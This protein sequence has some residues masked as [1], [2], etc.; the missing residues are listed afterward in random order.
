M[1]EVVEKGLKKNRHNGLKAGA[2]HPMHNLRHHSD[3]G[4]RSRWN[5]IGDIPHN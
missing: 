4:A 1:T 5:H 3:I 2:R